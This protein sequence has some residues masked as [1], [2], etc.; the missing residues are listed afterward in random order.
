V[1]WTKQFSALKKLFLAGGEAA[2]KQSPI[3]LSALIN[4]GVRSCRHCS[5]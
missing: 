2:L 3:K 4:N 5:R 1:F